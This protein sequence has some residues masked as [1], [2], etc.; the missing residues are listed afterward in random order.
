MANN[1]AS[2]RAILKKLHPSAFFETSRAPSRQIP[3]TDVV[4]EDALIILRSVTSAMKP[5]PD[6]GFVGVTCGA[7]LVKLIKRSAEETLLKSQCRMFVACYDKQAYVSLGKADTQAKRDDSA[8]QAEA[9]KT[10]DV[11]KAM[12]M[13]PKPYLSLDKPLPDNWNELL[14]D[15]AGFRQW[16]ISWVWEQLIASSDHECRLTVP[17]KKAVVVDG[18]C[19]TRKI[20][21]RI[22]E[23]L[24][25]TYLNEDGE[26]EDFLEL[27]EEK[28]P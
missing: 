8:R 5:R 10:A 23:R 13:P 20:V 6:S 17:H 26:V 7:D 3:A 27:P 2:T 16:A 28:D 21:E 11:V 1:K 25:G 12:V 14:S 24:R 22:N 9:D 15:R 4:I 18:H 19:F